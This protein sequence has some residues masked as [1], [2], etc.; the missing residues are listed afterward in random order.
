MFTPEE[1]RRFVR[2]LSDS[3]LPAAILKA[4]LLVLFF[5]LAIHL[6]ELVERFEARTSA[7]S[8]ALEK[9]K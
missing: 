7:S 6:V 8:R 4:I 9:V 3:D 2:R 1:R 5:N